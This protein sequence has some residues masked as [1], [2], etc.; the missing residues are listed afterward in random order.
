MTTT[1][2]DWVKLIDQGDPDA[3]A[4]AASDVLD[5]PVPPKRF[6]YACQDAMI[7]APCRGTCDQWSQDTWRSWLKNRALAV[8]AYEDGAGCESPRPWAV[9]T[10]HIGFISIEETDEQLAILRRPEKMKQPSDPDQPAR[11]KIGKTNLVVTPI[12][13][14]AHRVAPIESQA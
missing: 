13:R 7:T 2:Y 11:S 3:L 12:D 4:L 9:G 6:L 5:V 1:A 14:V 8:G 10:L